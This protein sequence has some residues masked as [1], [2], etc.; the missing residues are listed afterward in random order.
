MN[1]EESPREIEHSGDSDAELMQRS[2]RGDSTAYTALIQKYQ[3]PLVNFFRRLGVYTEAEDLVQESFVRIFRA[4]TRYRVKAKFRTYL[5]AVARSVYVD[6]V[7]RSARRGDAMTEYAEFLATQGDRLVMQSE[8]SLDVQAAVDALPEK[9]RV[10]VV[11]SIFQG[12]KYREVAEVLD[13]PE[14]TVKSRMSLAVA[15]LKETLNDK[16]A[17]KVTYRS[18]TGPK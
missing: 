15:Q 1:S 8:R 10:V 6:W 7:R 14:G 17:S 5:Y 16:P 9:L 11:L 13:I 18:D 4:R 3:N 12:L 2:S